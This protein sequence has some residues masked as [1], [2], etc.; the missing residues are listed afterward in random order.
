MSD[1]IA[2]RG[3]RLH[4]HHG[5]YP[6][7]R[8][9]GQEFVIDVLLSLDTTAAAKSDDVAD[10]VHYG[11]LTEAL[12]AAVAREPVNLLETL[13]ERLARLCLEH[14]RVTSVEVTVHK[15]NAPIPH[16]FEDVSVTI[17]RTRELGLHPNF[18]RVGLAPAPDGPDTTPPRAAA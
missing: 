17:Q 8:E 18:R 6:A 9:R 12:A 10:T 4:G 3:L 2:L 16:E 13:A 11:E 7:E 5:V 15:P 1:R 14:T